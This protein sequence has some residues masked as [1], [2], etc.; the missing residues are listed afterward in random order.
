[1]NR[2][3]CI[4]WITGQDRITVS[5]T[6]K[7]YVNKVKRLAKM[8]ENDVDFIENTDGSIV[9]HLPLKALK[10]SIISSEKRDYLNMFK[11]KEQHEV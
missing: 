7:K 11:K 9:A 8:H 3:N 6:Q 1:M 5:V 10:L 2:E 4:E